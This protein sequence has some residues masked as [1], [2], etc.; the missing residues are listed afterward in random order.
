[1]LYQFLKSIANQVGPV[2]KNIVGNPA[3]GQ[4][5]IRVPPPIYI[6]AA[7]GVGDA[8]N[9]AYD[10]YNSLDEEGKNKIQAAIKWVLKDLALGGLGDLTSLPIDTIAELAEQVIKHLTQQGYATENP[11]VKEYIQSDL[12]QQLRGSTAD[13]PT[14]TVNGLPVSLSEELEARLL[15]PWKT[16]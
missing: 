10:W 7:R 3:L 13:I 8:A 9:S 11:H 2:I 12:T 15:N 1:M 14:V 4:I 6:N 5:L 16:S